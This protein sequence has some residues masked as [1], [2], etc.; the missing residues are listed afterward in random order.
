MGQMSIW[1]SS[2]CIVGHSVEWGG[3]PH[4]IWPLGWILQWEELLFSWV[5]SALYG[6]RIWIEVLPCPW[7]LAVPQRLG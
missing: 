7:L 5:Y 6:W 4:F 3:A 2:M 1:S